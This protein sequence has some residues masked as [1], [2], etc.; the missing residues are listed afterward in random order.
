MDKILTKDAVNNKA[1][2]VTV[3]DGLIAKGQEYVVAD[4]DKKGWELVKNLYIYWPGNIMIGPEG[5]IRTCDPGDNFE[6]NACDAGDKTY[7][8][9]YKLSHDMC[10]AMHAYN[11]KP[12]DAK[13]ASTA[14]TKMKPLIVDKTAWTYTNTPYN[15]GCG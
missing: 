2:M 7:N 14:A 8:Q 13:L 5:A 3:L 9:K 12:T 10:E 11:K 6:G 15:K 4:P 1:H